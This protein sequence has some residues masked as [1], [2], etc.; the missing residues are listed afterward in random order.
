[1]EGQ[2]AE[3]D[4]QLRKKHQESRTAIEQVEK[5]KQDWESRCK[6]FENKLKENKFEIVGLEES[7][8]E[9]RN[10][11]IQFQ[12]I[13]VNYTDGRSCASC[14]NNFRSVMEVKRQIP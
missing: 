14:R 10:I 8:E 9:M 1:M 12:Q 2:L 4:E 13:D 7:N 3:K 11:I 5:E 6:E